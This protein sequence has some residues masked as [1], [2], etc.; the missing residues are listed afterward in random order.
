MTGVIKFS[1]RIKADGFRAPPKFPAKFPAA[2][3]SSILLIAA[4]FPA[5][6]PIELFQLIFC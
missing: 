3:N 5:L 6:G 4:R 2:G 1:G